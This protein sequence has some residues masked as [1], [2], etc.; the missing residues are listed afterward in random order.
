MNTPEL[1]RGQ[2]WLREQ[3]NRIANDCEITVGALEWSDPTSDDENAIVRLSL[4]LNGKSLEERFTVANL[5][6]L[7]GDRKTRASVLSQK[8]NYIAETVFGRWNLQWLTMRKGG[9]VGCSFR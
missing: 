2:H 1:V 7:K 9:C 3:V 6:E 5:S 8:Y 4:V